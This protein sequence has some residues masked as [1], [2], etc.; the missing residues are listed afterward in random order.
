MLRARRWNQ[1]GLVVAEG[2]AVAEA[3]GVH[4]Q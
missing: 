1:D 4:L 2:E 3:V